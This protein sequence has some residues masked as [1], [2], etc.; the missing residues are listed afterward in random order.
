MLPSPASRI[1]ESWGVEVVVAEEQW[2]QA[3]KDYIVKLEYL[4]PHG[5]EG[6][7]HTTGI[8]SSSPPSPLA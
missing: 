6:W 2:P 4:S 8:S 3:L 1:L 7:W 5:E